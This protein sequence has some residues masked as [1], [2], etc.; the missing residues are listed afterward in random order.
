MGG[1]LPPLPPRIRRHWAELALVVDLACEADMAS[2][3]S[4]AYTVYVPG[5]SSCVMDKETGVTTSES[6]M[7]YVAG[8]SHYIMY[9]PSETRCH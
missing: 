2:L 8:Y 5:P 7:T 3:L 4:D 6:A 1:S 9:L